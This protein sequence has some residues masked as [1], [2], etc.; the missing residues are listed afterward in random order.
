MQCHDFS[1]GGPATQSAHET[2]PRAQSSRCTDVRLCSQSDGRIPYTQLLRHA[3]LF[4]A[5]GRK[6]EGVKDEGGR[7]CSQFADAAGEIV[8]GVPEP[9]L[10]ELNEAFAAQVIYCRDRIGIDPERL[11]VN[12]GA[13]SI[14]HPYGMT[15][16]R[17]V[18]TLAHEMRR[19]KALHGIVTMCVGGGQGAAGLFE[20]C[21]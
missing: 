17:L 19:R 11:N 4:W 10:W 13:I 8:P 5:R 3:A 20:A 16:S 6:S 21:S 1:A 14:G 7:R 2:E 12:G 18:G 9:D 15:G